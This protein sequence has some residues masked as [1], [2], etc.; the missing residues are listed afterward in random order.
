[1]PHISKHLDP[2]SNPSKRLAWWDVAVR[3]ARVS[4]LMMAWQSQLSQLQPAEAQSQLTPQ[5]QVG[6][7]VEEF[8]LCGQVQVWLQVQALGWSLAVI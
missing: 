1:M 3:S 5:W 6:P 8:S 4:N 7:Q 2:R